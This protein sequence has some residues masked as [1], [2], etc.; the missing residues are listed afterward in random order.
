MSKYMARHGDL[1]IESVSKISGKIKKDNVLLEGEVTGHAHRVMG[2]A[3]VY[4][5]DTGTVYFKV[6]QP[7]KITHEE[8]KTIEITP[9][10]YKVTRQREYDPYEGVRNVQD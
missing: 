5:T 7:S 6:L 2:D 8:H 10:N 4:Q 9:G 1:L 3:K